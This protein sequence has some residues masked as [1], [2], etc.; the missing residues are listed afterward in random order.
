MA[1]LEG[2]FFFA[3]ALFAL[4]KFG[5]TWASIFW[6]G[7]PGLSPQGDANQPVIG[8]INISGKEFDLTFSECNKL[9]ETLIDAKEAARTSK[10]LGMDRTT[11]PHVSFMDVVSD[12][13]QNR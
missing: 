12:M 8:S 10:R 3:F 5:S 7:K 13:Q 2:L 6:K 1:F 4:A 9:I 11:T